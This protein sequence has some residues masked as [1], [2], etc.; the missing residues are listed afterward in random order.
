M[1]PGTLYVLG[2]GLGVPEINAP[3][4]FTKVLRTVAKKILDIANKGNENFQKVGRCDQDGEPIIGNP[5]CSRLY[6]SLGQSLGQ[7]L[8]CMYR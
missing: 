8:D 2:V 7:S 4:H 3:L 1:V 5:I 6:V